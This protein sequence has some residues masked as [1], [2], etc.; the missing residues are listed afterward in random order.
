MILNHKK[1]ELSN[2]FY[3]NFFFLNYRMS[4]IEK[5][6]MKNLLKLHSMG[7]KQ[8]LADKEKLLSQII[9]DLENYATD[10]LDKD[11]HDDLK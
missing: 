2:V 7:P 11:K 8:E 9:N 10:I 3:C 1:N 5:D 4:T 6:K